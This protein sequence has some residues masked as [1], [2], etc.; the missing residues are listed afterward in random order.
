MQMVVD[1]ARDDDPAGAGEAFEPGGDIDAVAVQIAAL[2]HDIAEIDA[3]PQLQP[4]RVAALD[5]HGARH[6]VDHAREFREH[7][8]AE[9]LDQPATMRRQQNRDHPVPQRRESSERAGLILL[10]ERRV[11]DHVGRQ[12]RSQAPL[13]AR[14]HHAEPLLR[15]ERYARYSTP[16]TA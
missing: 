16:A 7:A 1:R 5:G 8:V 3:D 11:A 2:D 10:D 9:Q 12:D 4:A 15:P 6:R 14:F 13:G